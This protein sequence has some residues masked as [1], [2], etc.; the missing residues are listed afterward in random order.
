MGIFSLQSF[1]EENASSFKFTSLSR[2]SSLAFSNGTKS[3]ILLVDGSSIAHMLADSAVAP[4]IFAPFPKLFGGDLNDLFIKTRAI[5]S[6]FASL[7]VELVIVTD[8]PSVREDEIHK[9]ETKISRFQQNLTNLAKIDAYCTT[10]EL[11][12]VKRGGKTFFPRYDT[13]RNIISISLTSTP[14]IDIPVG[15]EITGALRIN[16]PDFS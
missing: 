7:G 9:R 13:V 16:A 12:K 8:G 2:V 6:A 14:F 15:N 5:V 4:S 10:S 11:G 1:L 3:V